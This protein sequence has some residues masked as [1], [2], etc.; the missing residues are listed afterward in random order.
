M[1]I[2]DQAAMV[3]KNSLI[4]SDLHIGITSDL[5]KAGIIVPSQAEKFSERLNKLGKM[6]KAK[7]LIIVGDLKH[8]VKGIS[9]NESYE[10]PLFFSN[11]RFRKIVIVKG[12]HD[13]RIESLVPSN[14]KRK[15]IVKEWYDTN[16]YHI[17]HGHRILNT[18]L[19]KIIMGH[20]QPQVRFVDKYA[21][22]T[23]PCWIRGK[24]E[25]DRKLVILPA[26]NELCGGTVMN[27]SKLLGPIVK[28]LNYSKTKAY[29]LDGTDLG[30]LPSLK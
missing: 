16:G 20:I 23:L 4:V 15:I 22:Y 1:F 7:Q 29:L 5:Y 6:V 24:L 27:H 13:G 19:D 30:F 26:F 18:K 3:V 12:N 28:N 14:L 9:K 21:T 17:T 25:D 11:L 2:T 10:I 8:F